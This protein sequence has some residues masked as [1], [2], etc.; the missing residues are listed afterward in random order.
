MPPP[1]S[2]SPMWQTKSY[3]RQTL[4]FQT[5]VSC[6]MRFNEFLLKC[7]KEIA[8][9]RQIEKEN[10]CWWFSMIS[11]EQSKKIWSNLRRRRFLKNK[12]TQIMFYEKLSFNKSLKKLQKG[13]RPSKPA[14]FTPKS[15]RSRSF[16]IFFRYCLKKLFLYIWSGIV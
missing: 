12:Y 2:P 15:Q 16:E 10:D 1:P 4:H 6:L 14:N 13:R 9:A 7:E 11:I 8:R 5:H 3:L